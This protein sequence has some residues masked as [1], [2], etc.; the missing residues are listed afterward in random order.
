MGNWGIGGLRNWGWIEWEI[1]RWVDWGWLDGLGIGLNGM[2][3]LGGWERWMDGLEIG[4]AGMGT[5]LAGI[6]GLDWEG[7]MD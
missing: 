5:G 7:G 4:L 2:D 1:G 6:D 3:G